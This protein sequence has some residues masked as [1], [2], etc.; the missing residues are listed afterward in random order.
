MLCRADGKLYAGAGAVVLDADGINIYGGKLTLSEADG[1]GAGQLYIDAN[2]DIRADP[3]AWGYFRANNLFVNGVSKTHTIH[4]RDGATTADLGLPANP[5]RD[6]ILNR[7]LCSIGAGYMDMPRRD[8]APTAY[9]GR[10]YYPNG[11][12]RWVCWDAVN[13]T[14]R[15]L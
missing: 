2:G 11:T 9:A 14:W 15:Y 6:I 10:S 12:G 7:N 4:P 5:W 3:A 1:T 8:S 13:S